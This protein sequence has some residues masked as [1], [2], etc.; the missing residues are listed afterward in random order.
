MLSQ[1]LLI[2]QRAEEIV[3]EV[4]TVSYFGSGGGLRTVRRAKGQP[5]AALL[6]EALASTGAVLGADLGVAGAESGLE[7]APPPPPPPL[8]PPP[9]LEEVAAVWGGGGAP[10]GEA[11]S[12]APL[13]EAAGLRVERD[14]SVR[15]IGG[16][17]LAE[18][19]LWPQ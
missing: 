19:F 14:E 10:Q 12:W 11:S 6:D 8:P 7:A 1:V 5:A 3:D 13:V 9:S 2:T 15:L 4:A 18:A 16:F 17:E